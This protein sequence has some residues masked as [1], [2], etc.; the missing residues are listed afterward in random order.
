MPGHDM[1]A[2]TSNGL[3]GGSVIRLHLY[4]E[5]L[6]DLGDPEPEDEVNSWKETERRVLGHNVEFGQ[7]WGNNQSEMSE[8]EEDR[9]ESG[10]ESGG[11][12]DYDLGMVV[13]QDD[14]PEHDIGDGSDSDLSDCR[15]IR[16]EVRREQEALDIEMSQEIREALHKFKDRESDD[17]DTDDGIVVRMTTQM[18]AL[19][20]LNQKPKRRKWGWF[21]MLLIEDLDLKDG[22]G[23]TLISDQQKGLEKAVRE[24]L[25]LVE[26]RFCAR[27][28]SSNLTKKHPSE[29]IKIAFWSSS[30]ATHPEA[31]KSAMRDLERHSKGAAAKMKS[32]ESKL[33]YMPLIDMLTEIHDMIM[34]RLH[35]K[36]DSMKSIDCVVLPT[37]KKELDLAIRDSNDCRVLWDGRQNFQVKWRGIGYCVNLEEKTCSCRV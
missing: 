20:M 23:F 22:F 31:F 25:P 17:D 5:K 28:L 11:G 34:K 19:H 16:E 36:R 18:M 9:D 24:L 13:I 10:G 6:E 29:A 1:S 21:L 27:H 3:G 32:L 7:D 4:T 12:E 15:R 8:N 33:W 37:I 30:T 2:S 26:H 35:K 14:D